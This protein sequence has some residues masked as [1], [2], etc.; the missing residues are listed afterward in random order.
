MVKSAL[1]GIRALLARAGPHR[2]PQSCRT[3]SADRRLRFALAQARYVTRL[4]PW[5]RDSPVAQC[6]RAAVTICLGA[7]PHPVYRL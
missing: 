3:P 5:L 1:P 2:Q 4:H 7:E 6:E